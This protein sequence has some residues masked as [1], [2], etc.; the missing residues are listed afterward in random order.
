MRKK[1]VL[2]LLLVV[3]MSNG[4][5]GAGKITGKVTFMGPIPKTELFTCPND[6]AVC[7]KQQSLDRLV[8]GKDHGV[9]NTLV[10]IKNPPPASLSLLKPTTITQDHC[11]FVPHIVVAAKGSSVQFINN[12]DV[13]HNCHGYYYSYGSTAERTTAFN[14]AQPTA[15]QKNNQELRKQG[16]ISLECDAGH[17]WMT[18]WIWVTANPFA[19]ITNSDGEFSFDGLPPG[20]YTIVI[21]HEG[22]DM[23]SI[24]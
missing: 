1:I 10:F 5:R 19:T 3:C 23:V 7:G 16:M 20:K 9:A 15:G 13:L 22:W 17:T 21:W 4:S 11:R 14:L 24:S 6:Q 8:I 12:D 18:A 2:C